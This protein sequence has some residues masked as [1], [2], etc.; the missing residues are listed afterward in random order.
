LT[1][2][3]QHGGAE[4]CAVGEGRGLDPRGEQSGEPLHHGAHKR[5]TR[6]DGIG[7]CDSATGHRGAVTCGR[8]NGSGC[9]ERD[10]RERRADRK[11]AIGDPLGSQLAEQPECVLIT[12]LDDGGQCAETLHHREGLGFRADDR[13]TDVRVEGDD[14]PPRRRILKKGLQLGCS[15]LEKSCDRAGV[16][17]RA[18]R[19]FAHEA[20]GP[21]DQEFVARR[22][23][24]IER[25]GCR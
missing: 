16:H 5:V 3:H 12:H 8:Q 18:G 24:R 13:R 23:A 14:R 21:V 7:H 6:A 11:Q 10:D 17:D 2:V 20:E 1:D 9:S 15:G 25:H 22:S 19:Q 4:R